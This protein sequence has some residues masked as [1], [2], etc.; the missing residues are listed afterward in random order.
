MFHWNMHLEVLI[1]LSGLLQRQDKKEREDLK[2][3]GSIARRKSKK[4]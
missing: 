4:S 1:S 3:G 2:L